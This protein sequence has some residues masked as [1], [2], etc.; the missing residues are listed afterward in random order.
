MPRR[1]RDSGF[2]LRVRSKKGIQ[3][4]VCLVMP[5]SGRELGLGIWDKTPASGFRL[6]KRDSGFGTKSGVDVD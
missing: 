5:Q 6:K 2:R 4:S 1:G 3:S